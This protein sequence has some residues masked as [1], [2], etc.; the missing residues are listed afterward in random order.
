[1]HRRFLSKA[2]V[3]P[4]KYSGTVLLPSTTFDQRANAAKREPEIQKFWSELKISDKLFS[5]NKGELFT[6][7]DGPPY[8]NG[9]L[10]VGH[11]LNKILKDI[12]NKYHTLNGKRVKFIPGWDCHGL[13]IELKVIQSIN[14]KD[15]Q[16]LSP[17]QL[18]DKATEFANTTISHQ[19]EAFKR[20]G[21]WGEWDQPY[22][23]MQKNYEADQIRVFAAMV[24]LGLIYR[25]LKP[26][27]WSPSSHS[28]L[29]EAELEY[30]D[31]H[32][33]RSIYAGFKVTHP[34]AALE[35][36][37]SPLKQEVRVAV[38]TTTPW[39][40][41]ANLAVAVRGDLRYSIISHPLFQPHCCF[42]VA[43]DLVQQ[44]ST[45]CGVSDDFVVHGTLVGLDLCGT[46]YQH[47]LY[48]SLDSNRQHEV[49]IGGDYIN[50]DS[51]TGLV[52]TAPGH[53]AEDYAVGQRLGLPLLSPVDDRGRFTIEAGE[54]FVGKDVLSSGTSAVIDH[55][56]NSGYLIH[57]HAY[58][59]RYPYDWRTKKPTIF[60]ATEQWFASVDKEEYR[61]DVVKAIDTVQWIPSIGKNR[62]T[63][64]VTS[65][66]DW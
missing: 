37:T 20:Y 65:R 18:R 43:S 62:I 63:A 15:L 26:V 31:N 10:H 66:K 61:A 23:T 45:I 38:W 6:L 48:S 19:R 60:R 47:P 35:L 27:H 25:G 49:V 29:A 53:G 33:S 36:I 46:L 55:L 13:P 28:A 44:F 54:E 57:E 39:T 8:A 21:V 41:P 9:D 17:L 50:T 1:M 34:S 32:I 2:R 24:R 5:S 64:T 51:G 30:P 40:L 42:V 22:T 56:R 11:A 3:T 7:H 16:N 58:K 59:H 12:I 14:K 4:G 52:H